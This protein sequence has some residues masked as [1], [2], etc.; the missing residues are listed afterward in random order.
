MGP[1]CSHKKRQGKSSLALHK[2]VRVPDN[3]QGKEKGTPKGR[4]GAL[5]LFSSMLQAQAAQIQ[6]AAV[7]LS[8][9]GQGDSLPPGVFYEHLWQS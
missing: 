5:C 9:R 3:L 1:A 2:I 6:Q 8:V 7:V 4:S